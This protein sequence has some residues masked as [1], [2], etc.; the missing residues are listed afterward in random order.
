MWETNKN[1]FFLLF[2]TALLRLLFH[3][4]LMRAIVSLSIAAPVFDEVDEILPLSVHVLL[5]L[6]Q[7]FPIGLF[8]NDLPTSLFVAHSSKAQASR[9]RSVALS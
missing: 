1:L 7:K 5:K 2:T 6:F 4:L 9:V 8:S 3:L